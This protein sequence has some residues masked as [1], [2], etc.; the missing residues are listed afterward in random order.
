MEVLMHKYVT[1]APLAPS[2]L[3]V[4][5]A[6]LG[7]FGS[8]LLSAIA[9]HLVYRAGWAVAAPLPA[10]VVGVLWGKGRLGGWLLPDRVFGRRW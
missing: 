9:V 1:T 3:D 10:L 4:A 8:T 5:R 7:L 2:R 6:A